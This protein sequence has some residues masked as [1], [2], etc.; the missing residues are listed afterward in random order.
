MLGQLET[1]CGSV[2]LNSNV[3]YVPQKAWILVSMILFSSFSFV[4]SKNATVKDNILFGKPF[5]E[6]KYQKALYASALS[7]DLSI[8]FLFFDHLILI[9]CFQ[10]LFLVEICARLGLFFKI[11]IE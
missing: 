3:A 5:N 4:F 10:K 1:A 11:L 8:F 2:N 7:E 6:E 9:F